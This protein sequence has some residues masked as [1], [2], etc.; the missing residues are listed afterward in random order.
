MKNTRAIIVVTIIFFTPIFFWTIGTWQKIAMLK[1]EETKLEQT[2]RENIEVPRLEDLEPVFKKI[3]PLASE[4]KRNKKEFSKDCLVSYLCFYKGKRIG[5]ISLFTLEGQWGPMM[6]MMGVNMDG[7]ITH[8]ELSYH[9]E[10]PGCGSQIE[11]R[12][13]LDQFKGKTTQD[14]IEIY[15]DLLEATDAVKGVDCITRATVSSRA[16]AKGVK[17]QLR[18]IVENVIKGEEDVWR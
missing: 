16:I 7:E 9:T 17:E 6:L 10:T 11:K 14:P 1:A 13:F 18:L 12:P 3:L 15:K 5:V 4:F 8:I 2:K